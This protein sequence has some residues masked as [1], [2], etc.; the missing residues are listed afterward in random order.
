MVLRLMPV[1]L[2]IF[3]RHAAAALAANFGNPHR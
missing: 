3:H 2:T 1:T